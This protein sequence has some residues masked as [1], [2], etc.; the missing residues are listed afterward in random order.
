[1]KRSLDLLL[2]LVQLI[3]N[4]D[5]RVM[6]PGASESVSCLS[7]SNGAISED[8]ELRKL[9]NILVSF[10]SKMSQSIIRT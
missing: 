10:H 6:K 1:M 3:L 2:L 4:F 7:E 8:K 9:L 5:W